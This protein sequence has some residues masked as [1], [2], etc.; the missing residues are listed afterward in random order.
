[1]PEP[2]EVTIA[3]VMQT[4][5]ADAVRHAKNHYGIDLDFSEASLRQID[6][7][8]DD[9]MRG[10]VIEA[11][12]LTPEEQE[13][14]WVY[15]KMIGGYVGEVIIRNLGGAWQA[16]PTDSGGT[17]VKLMAAGRIEA[18]PP[19]GVWRTLTE[20][21]RSMTSYYRSLR[22]ILGHGDERTENGLEFIRLPPLSPEVPRDEPR[23]KPWWRFW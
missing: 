11:D 10:A 12:R 16:K 13:D 19:E 22:A 18:S 21:Y 7:M 3:D 15:C 20:P 8:L 2:E 14:L 4:Y 23:G 9:R 5:A 6:R 1:L 17:A